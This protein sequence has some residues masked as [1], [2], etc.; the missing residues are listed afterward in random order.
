TTLAWVNGAALS[1]VSYFWPKVGNTQQDSKDSL[2]DT[3]Y[4]PPGPSTQSN[5]HEVNSEYL[6]MQ[7]QMKHQMEALEKMK[8]QIEFLQQSML[9]EHPQQPLIKVV[10]PSSPR[11]THNSS[12]EQVENSHEIS[13][14]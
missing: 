7:E 2:Q 6:K 5:Q 4:P 3:S 11:T 9:M 8:T 13:S 14:N 12:P 1:F 10:V